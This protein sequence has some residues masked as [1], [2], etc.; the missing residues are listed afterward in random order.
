MEIQIFNVSVWEALRFGINDLV[1]I[2]FIFTFLD[3]MY[4]RKFTQNTTYVFAYFI[5]V[6][7]SLTVSCIGVPLLN[8]INSLLLINILSIVLYKF[9]IVTSILYNIC[10]LAISIFGDIAS[11]S[12][13]SAVSGNTLAETVGNDLSMFVSCILGWIVMLLS[14]K[15][16][17]AI[18]KK[19]ERTVVKLKELLFFVCITALEIAITG[20]FLLIIE[21]KSS[22]MVLTIVLGCFFALDIY[23]TYLIREATRSGQLKYELALSQQQVNMQLKHF[24][25]LMLTQEKARKTVHDAKKHILAVE[26]LFLSDSKQNAEEYATLFCNELDKLSFD[27]KCSN[28]LLGIIISSKLQEAQERQIILKPFL[29]DVSLDFINDFDITAI[30]ANLLDNSIEECSDL[31]LE[32]RQIK[33]TLRRKNDFIVINVS[34]PVRSK[35]EPIKKVFKTSKIGHEG[36]GLSNVLTAVEKY[37]G[38]FIAEIEN[39]SFVVSITIPII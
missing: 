9:N 35:P 7:V 8:A 19:D 39:S 34:N 18:F 15:I 11:A 31:P 1:I 36:L 4:L 30:F 10:F 22:G 16:L 24:N 23:I 5:A 12:F 28:Q 17:I 27:F 25:W 32:L 13:L 33:L 6:F 37:N 3:K 14:Y 20:Y 21:G 2:A 38:N 26:G 29:E